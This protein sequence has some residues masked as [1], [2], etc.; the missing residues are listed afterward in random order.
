[1]TVTKTQE[2]SETPTNPYVYYK[3]CDAARAAGAAP[4]H[5]GDPGYRSEL[6]RDGDGV[7]CEPYYG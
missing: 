5:R 6:D 1:M 2:T 7:A 3:D 4:L